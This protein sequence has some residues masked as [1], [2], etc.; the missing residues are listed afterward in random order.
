MFE[1]TFLTSPLPKATACS[2]CCCLLRRRDFL[3]RNNSSRLFSSGGHCSGQL[4]AGSKARNLVSQ[5]TLEWC[6][7]LN[8][9]SADPVARRVHRI[10]RTP[11]EMFRNS[12][13]LCKHQPTQQVISSTYTQ[14]SA[15]PIF[16]TI[17]TLI[18]CSTFQLCPC[19]RHIASSTSSKNSVFLATC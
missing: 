13:L 7:L 11:T 3:S 9:S 19:T 5:Y 14:H 1:R 18:L 8:S 10:F 4:P 17:N 15:A 16:T 6:A 12:P 2:S